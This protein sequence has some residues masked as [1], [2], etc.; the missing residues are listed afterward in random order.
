MAAEAPTLSAVVARLTEPEINLAAFGGIVYPLS[1]IV[2]SPIIMLLSAS[3]AL[4][5]DWDSYLRLRRFMMRVSAALTVIHALL[6]FT[7]LYDLVVVDLIHPPEA[8]VEPAR[9]GLMIMLPWTWAIAYRRFNQGVLIRF[10]HA[11]AV[12]FGTAVRLGADA[13][14]LGAGYLIGTLPG[15]VVATVALSIGVVS[16]AVY[17]GLRVRPVLRDQL[18]AA[19]P[20]AQPLTF[21]SLIAFYIPL[22]MTSLLRLLAEPLSSAA[23]S[24]MPK[25]LAS[26]AVWSVVTGFIFLLRSLGMAY[27]EV[28]ITLL[29]DPH[30]SRN[31]RRFMYFLASLVTILLLIVVST[32]LAQIWFERVTGL[33]PDLAALSRHG[34][35]I[36]LLM[37]GLNVLQS[38]YQGLL[39]HRRHTRA[40]TES[41]VVY[42]VTS[43]A[44]LWGG[45][46]WG[47]MAGLYVGLAAIGF[48]RL[49]QTIWL[50]YRSRST[51]RSIEACEAASASLLV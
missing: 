46:A 33:K 3:T 6:A 36:A 44:I 25:A 5:K 50:W 29:D 43:G 16:E 47:Q 19:P 31:L 7:P 2:E 41:I 4:S 10:G 48:G 24:R 20:V 17:A 28:V 40:I 49:T 1:L 15:I 51:L 11:R 9:L 23:L 39:V 30:S 27:Q 12:G 32:P 34:L 45:V 18:R 14:V 42:L 35:W 37:P 26:L 13:L 38:W 22:A 21:R 8:I